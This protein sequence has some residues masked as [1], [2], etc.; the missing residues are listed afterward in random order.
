MENLEKRTKAMELF[1]N[2]KKS[3]DELNQFIGEDT[4]LHNYVS[5]DYPF[6]E[7]FEIVYEKVTKWSDKTTSNLVNNKEE[8]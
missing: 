7:D 4:G 5:Y 2:L 3:F 6:T 8:Y 1:A